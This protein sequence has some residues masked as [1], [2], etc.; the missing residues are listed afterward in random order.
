METP[1]K[2][3]D[4]I[5][6][7]RLLKDKDHANATRLALQTTHT[8]KES[9]KTDTKATKDGTIASAGALETSIE[10]E[11]LGSDT[12]TND[13]LHYAVKNQLEV[14]AWEIDFTKK[15]DATH[16]ASQYGTGFLSEWETPAD[17]ED[18]ATI[19]TTLTVNGKMVK[20]NATVSELDALT[21]HNFFR[22][23]VKGAKE[24]APIDESPKYDATTTSE[25]QTVAKQ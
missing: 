8:I 3:K 21:V 4:K 15:I 25:K 14:E 17:V 23:T 7:F 22:D 10:I 19:K 6:M 1:I 13:L 5:L 24:E 12:L 9:S 18:N 2:G 20:G 11:A 16:Y